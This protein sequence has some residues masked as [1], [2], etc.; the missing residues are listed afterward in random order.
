MRTLCV[1]CVCDGACT[2]ARAPSGLP[3]LPHCCAPQAIFIL[4][5]YFG[6]NQSYLQAVNYG[7]ALLYDPLLSCVILTH[8][9]ISCL[10]KPGVGAGL[11]WQVRVCRTQGARGSLPRDSPSHV[12]VPV[13]R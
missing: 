2:S 6:N 10:T 4:G 13:R 5:S 3:W 8:E 12:A 7:P 11:S 1:R 9:N